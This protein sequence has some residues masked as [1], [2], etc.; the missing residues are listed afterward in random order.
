MPADATSALFSPP[1]GLEQPLLPADATLALFSLPHDLEQ[2]LL[3]ADA[4]SALFSPPHDLEQPLFPLR[5]IWA[6]ASATTLA[7]RLAFSSLSN[8]KPATV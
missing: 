8:V 5:D 6:T 1:H 7:A 2:P 3:P 4:T